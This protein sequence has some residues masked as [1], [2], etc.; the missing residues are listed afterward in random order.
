MKIRM[1]NCFHSIGALR[2]FHELIF[3]DIETPALT[4]Y[5]IKILQFA[6][7]RA[8]EDFKDLDQINLRCQFASPCCVI[9]GGDKSTGVTAAQL[10]DAGLPTHYA[11][12][13]KGLA[14]YSHGRPHCI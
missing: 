6:A 3:F 12:I 5:L 14:G 9:T 7:M 13:P 4:G 8:K 2:S 1:V 11:M 10:L